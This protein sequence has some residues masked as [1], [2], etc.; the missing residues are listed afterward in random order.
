MDDWVVET[1]FIR[2]G[3][4]EKYNEKRASSVPS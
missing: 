2:N 3:L 1:L 4:V